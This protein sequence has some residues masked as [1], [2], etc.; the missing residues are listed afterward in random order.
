LHTNDFNNNNNSGA[1]RLATAAAC[2]DTATELFGALEEV[3]DYL[4]RIA[5]L[6]MAVSIFSDRSMVFKF[7]LNFVLIQ[8]FRRSPLRSCASPLGRKPWWI[9]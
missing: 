7:D 8:T 9:P 4:S 3:G 1:M 2:L 5:T 6:Q